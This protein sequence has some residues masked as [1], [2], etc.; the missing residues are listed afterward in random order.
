[1]KFPKYGKLSEKSKDMMKFPKEWE[2][3]ERH[4]DQNE[5]I[6]PI[7]TI[8]ASL[9]EFCLSDFY[10]IQKWIDYGRGI[11]DQ[12]IEIFNDMPVIFEN[13]YEEAKQ[14]ITS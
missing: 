9:P 1:L 10:I 8:K 12:S 2:P 7:E 4:F 14:R 11:G 3:P 5:L 13:I 6:K